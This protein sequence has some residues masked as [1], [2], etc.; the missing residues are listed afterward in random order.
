MKLNIYTCK[1]RGKLLEK[2]ELNLVKNKTRKLLV[3]LVKTG[4][5]TVHMYVTDF[6]KTEN[7]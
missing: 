4:L 2:K 6:G 1:K 5:A 7:K 3:L